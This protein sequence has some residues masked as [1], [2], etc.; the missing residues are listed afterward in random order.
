MKRLVFVCIAGVLGSF[1]FGCSPVAVGDPCTPEGEFS[2]TSGAANPT[3]LT[4]DV[5][6]VQCETRVC[7]QHYFSGRV[8]CPF[9]NGNVAGQTG[10]CRQ[11]GDRRGWYTI[12]GSSTGKLCCPVP[13]DPAETPIKNPVPAQCSSRPAAESVYCSCRCDIPD[14]STIPGATDDDRKALDRNNVQLCKCPTGYACKPLCDATNGN[15][16]IVPKGKWGS[17]CVKD[18]KNGSGYDPNDVSGAAVKCGQ[19][20][21]PPS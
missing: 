2:N 15:C 20:L 11:V 16:S 4:I 13:G 6:S 14:P 8:S 7:L 10:K 3:D 19:P 17:Y 21:P 9:G 1:S 12:D 18:G 5:N